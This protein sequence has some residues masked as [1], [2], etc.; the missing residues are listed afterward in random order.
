MS[1]DQTK[2]LFKSSI[3]MAIATFASRILGLARELTL[4]SVFGASGTTDAFLVAYRIP[5][6][7]R[8][9]FAEGNFSPSFVPIFTEVNQRSKEEA[10]KLLW[11]VFTLLGIITT[12]M[13]IGMIIFASELVTLFAPTFVADPEKFQVTVSM[14]QIMSPFLVVISWAALFMGVLNTLKIFFMPSFAPVF[15][16]VIMIIATIFVPPYFEKIGVNGIIALAF[17]VIIGGIVQATVQL[18]LVLSNG[19]FPTTKINLLSKESKKILNRVGIGTIGVAAA[20]INVLINTI[21]A[22]STV[23][24]AVSWLTYAFRLFQFPIGIM[25]VSI[26]GSNLVHFSDAWKAK[27]SD[28][29]ISYLSASYFLSL[30][31]MVPAF[32]LLYVMATPTTSLILERG[33]FTARDT[34]M[35][36]QA[37]ELY[38]IGLPFYGL[39]KIFGPVFYTI[40]KP[41]IPVVVSIASIVINIIFCVTLTPVYGFKILALGVTLS[42]ALNVLTQMVLI[43][44]F[45]KLPISF[46]INLKI[47][48]LFIA[49]T[50]CYFVTITAMYLF[51]LPT[52]FTT[53]ITIFVLT[54]LIGTAGYTMS[55]LLMGE[56]AIL[57]KT[58]K[59]K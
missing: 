19:L 52:N 4:A 14:L 24:G 8:D 9:L 13:S 49:G 59:R 25:G 51:P 41:Q 44:K 34:I 26:A 12:V 40:D 28:E 5:N 35:T 20:Q 29:A 39:Y 17:G 48:K 56:M 7:L 32:V 27:R 3:K 54:G 33:A 45:L 46:F 42:M 50:A 15:F 37:L 43:K 22:T 36:A 31:F 10:R 23:V 18:P 58:F 53:K 38:A 2:S 30:L 57:K 1:K 55:V 6:I 11:S 47:L 16:N 21:L